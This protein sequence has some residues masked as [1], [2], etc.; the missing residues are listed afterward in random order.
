M[1][2]Y[3]LNEATRWCEAQGWTSIWQPALVTAGKRRGLS[4]GVCILARRGIELHR[5]ATPHARFPHRLIA[6]NVEAPGYDKFIAC[7]AYFKDGIGFVGTNSTIASDISGIFH[8]YGDKGFGFVGADWNMEPERLAASKF[9]EQLDAHIVKHSGAGGTC[10]VKGTESHIDY[11]LA[12]RGTE[13]WIESV[14]ALSG[15]ARGGVKT[16]KPV[17]ALC[18]PKVSSLR[19]RT[20][21]K[22]QPLPNVVPIGPR[23]DH[24][25][26]DA[27]VDWGPPL[28]AA[29]LALD[30]AE[31]WCV[32]EPHN[33]LEYAYGLFCDAAEIE[34][35]VAT[36]SEPTTRGS[37]GREPKEVW[38]SLIEPVRKPLFTLNEV[39]TT[40]I[41]VGQL[42]RDMCIE[43][44][45]VDKNEHALMTG[46]TPCR[47]NSWNTRS[48]VCARRLRPWSGMSAYSP[49][50]WSDGTGSVCIQP[51]LMEGCS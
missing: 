11:F 19:M 31:S 24:G 45:V 39:C 25:R 7:C 32:K 34:I 38:A 26:S 10:F 40:E 41:E 37:R 5:H 22:P 35:I 27:M 29:R 30:L 48:L 6:G 4:G 44:I 14:A 51:V 42:C 3:E 16:H 18:A 17:V 23:F 9:V 47:I 21:K 8:S 33:A 2:G 13:R 1:S 20:L 50:G 43:G 28:Q 12:V 36:G 46:C 15:P 49:M